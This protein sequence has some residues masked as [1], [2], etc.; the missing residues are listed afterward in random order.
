MVKNTPGSN[1]VSPIYLT[2][3]Q[4]TLYFEALGG[5]DP[6]LWVSDGTATGTHHVEEGVFAVMLAP[7]GHRLLFKGSGGEPWISDGTVDGTHLVKDIYPGSGAGLRGVPVSIGTVALFVGFNPAHGYALWRTKGTTQGTVLVRNGRNNGPRYFN[8]LSR[9][10]GVG[11]LFSAFNDSA[12]G[13]EPWRSNGWPGGTEL[14]KDINPS[15]GSFP[16]GMAPLGTMALFAAEDGVHG[17]EL[18]STQGT[19]DSTNLLKDI[20]T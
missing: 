7:F 1:G 17:R 3:A 14:V 18:W 19:S 13:F 10:K 15:A 5:G 4:G 8:E 11:V 12:T 20:R 2:P 16:V 6:G 9:F